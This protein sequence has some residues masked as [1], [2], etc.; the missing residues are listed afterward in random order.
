VLLGVSA[1]F[2]SNSVETLD[3][4]AMLNN[5]NGTAYLASALADPT[6]YPTLDPLA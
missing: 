2:D 6:L 4:G 3:F 5:G 1:E